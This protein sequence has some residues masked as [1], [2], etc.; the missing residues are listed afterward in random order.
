M[1][2]A[3][4]ILAAMADE[5]E[6]YTAEDTVLLIDAETREISIPESERLFGARQDRDVERKR[7]RCPRIVGDNIDLSQHHIYISYVPSKQDGTYSQTEEVG[8][9]RC[10]DLEVD[11]EDI[12]FSWLVS[13]NVTREA[14]YVAFAMY[15]KQADASGLLKTK[16]H[17]TIAIGNVLNTLP[18]GSQVVERYPDVIEQI[19]ARLDSLEATGGTGSGTAGVGISSIDKTDTA[20]LVDTY[21]VSL[22]DGSSYDF[23][24]TNGKDGADGKSAYWYA[25]QGGYTGTEDDFKDKLAAEYAKPTY[26][27]QMTAEDTTADLQPNTLY[28]FPEMA[29]LTLTFAIPTDTTIVNEY[30]CIF[31]SGAAATALSIPDTVKIPDGFAVDANKVYE[32]SVLEDCLSYMSW[33]YTAEATA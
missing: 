29:S 23:T 20:G 14:G 27:A 30:H 6:A 4:E 25:Q 10:E 13:D 8:S 18:D 31:T 22:T 17:T 7:F 33:D 5:P 2:T 15:A 24:V 12:T 21:T 1:A 26:K 11:G 9:Y 32:L 16:W 19:L 3:D 28:V